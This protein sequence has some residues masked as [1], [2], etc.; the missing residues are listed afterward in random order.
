MSEFSPVLTKEQLLQQIGEII[1]RYENNTGQIVG[2]FIQPGMSNPTEI[3]Q[4][5]GGSF[6]EEKCAIKLEEVEGTAEFYAA[7]EE[8]IKNDLISRGWMISK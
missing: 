7:K 8:G 1:S 4:W 2:A 5:D 3:H 6:S